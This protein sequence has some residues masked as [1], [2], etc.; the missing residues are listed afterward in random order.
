MTNPTPNPLTKNWRWVNPQSVFYAHD[1]LVDEYGGGHGIR[2]QGLILSAISRPKHLAVYARPDIS[3]LAATYAHGIVKNHGFMD[4]NKRTGFFT[5]EI[6]LRHNGYVS[7]IATA[8][9]FDALTGVANN[10]MTQEQLAN[11]LR[12]YIEPY[13]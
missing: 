4:G 9:M 7:S 8:S 10:T 5:A 13:N 12:N 2:D 3:E 11:L 1:E 6:F